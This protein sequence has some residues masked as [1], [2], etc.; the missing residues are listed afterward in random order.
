MW[1]IQRTR[2]RAGKAG[3]GNSGPWVSDRSFMCSSNYN[4]KPL[5]YLRQGS[6]VFKVQDTSISMNAVEG[7][8]K[9]REKN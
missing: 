3:P 1:L 6:V 4:K 8:I 2:G 5:K 9:Q 7:R